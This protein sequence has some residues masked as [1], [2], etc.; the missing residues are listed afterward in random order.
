MDSLPSGVDTLVGEEGVQLSGGQKQRVSLARAVYSGAQVN[1]ADDFRILEFF[2]G[3]LNMYVLLNLCQDFFCWTFPS[4]KHFETIHYWFVF[5]FLSGTVFFP[6]RKKYEVCQPF[7]QP[8]TTNSPWGQ[9]VILMDDV[10]S[11]LDAHVGH[12]VFESV[13][14]KQLQGK[15]RI[16]V[17]HQIQYW[18]HPAVD[19][20]HTH[21]FFR[22]GF[23]GV[24]S[25][26]GSTE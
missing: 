1:L 3:S 23:F 22:K 20:S 8:P 6:L 18:S 2:S 19:R 16:M 15:T 14:C 7:S 25:G 26:F 12:Y 21:F 13:I 10:L 4:P 9:K 17:T 24:I 11:A 5:F